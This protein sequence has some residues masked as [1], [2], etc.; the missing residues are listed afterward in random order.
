MMIP[1]EDITIA[2]ETK[3]RIVL[4]TLSLLDDIRWKRSGAL[5]PTTLPTVMR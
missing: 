3:L 4:R 2:D 1:M 5:P